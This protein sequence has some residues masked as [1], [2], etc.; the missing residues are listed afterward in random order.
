MSDTYIKYQDWTHGTNV[1]LVRSRTAKAITQLEKKQLDGACLAITTNRAMAQAVEADARQMR[2]E[3]LGPL[4][5]LNVVWKDIFDQAG[6]VTTCGSA[7]RPDAPRAKQDARSVQ[8][9]EAAGAVS[10]ARTGLSELAFSGLGINPHFGTPPSALSTSKPLVPGG[11]TSGAA[12][13]VAHGLADL[14]MGTDTS[15]SIRIPAALNGI[16]GFRPSSSRYSKIGVHELSQTLDTVGTLSRSFDL[17]LVADRVLASPALATKVY[18][19]AVILDL[20]D[21]LGPTWSPEVFHAYDEALK[22]ASNAGWRIQIGRLQS[23]DDLHALLKAEGPLV[24]IEARRKYSGLLS[25]SE[26]DRIDPMIRARLS[27]APVLTDARIAKYIDKRSQLVAKSRSEIGNRLVAFPTVP[28]LRHDLA[29]YQ[30]DLKAAQAL[31]ARLLAATMVGSLL[32][33]PG[34]AVPLRNA[35]ERV[36]GSFLLSAASGNDGLLLDQAKH[37]IPQITHLPQS[38]RG[39]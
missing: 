21:T 31:N 11:S 4:A 36:Q 7:L 30:Y 26:S 13:L 16:L 17:L 5:G 39:K 24:A 14:G 9:I 34:L 35:E 1:P 38:K 19:K 22:C 18:E 28:S 20:S 29:T 15:G 23:V 10:L 2:G 33:W 3:P 32:D 27:Q 12:V 25:G 8:Q 37:I 6:E